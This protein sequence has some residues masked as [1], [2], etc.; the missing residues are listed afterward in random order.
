MQGVGHI[1][2]GFNQFFLFDK[3][4]HFRRGFGARRQHKVIGQAVD[5][6]FL[7]VFLNDIGWRNQR[8]RTGR[9]GGPQTGTDLAFGIWLQ[10][11]AVHVAGAA[12][13]D[14]TG[15]NVFCHGGF[16]KA[17]RSINFGFA[18]LHVG[19]I[20]HAAHA[21]V[22][23]NVAVGVN[24]GD[25]GFFTALF[26]IEVHPD[27]RGFCR[28]Q[29]VNDGHAGGSFDNGHIRQVEVTDLINPVGHFKQ[30]ADIN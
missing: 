22:V 7:T 6:L 10:Q 13:H 26:E 17:S 3:P 30:A 4:Q 5:G 2:C 19:F 12:A 23:V 29:R 24:N 1:L 20:D 18:C 16:H 21:A 9:G 15:H 25:N 14:V 11:V 8:D 28:D 27:F